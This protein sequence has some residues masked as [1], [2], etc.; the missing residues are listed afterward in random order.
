MRRTY[1]RLTAVQ[2]SVICCMICAVRR[3]LLQTAAGVWLSEEKSVLYTH[4]CTCTLYLSM[5]TADITSVSEKSEYMHLPHRTCMYC[6][7]TC[8]CT[9]TCVY[10][11]MFALHVHFFSCV[12]LLLVCCVHMISRYIYTYM[13]LM[14]RSHCQEHCEVPLLVTSKWANY[15]TVAVD[16]NHRKLQ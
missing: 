13:Y 4:T 9:C 3:N 15:W 11:L 1:T 2:V 16:C 6:A 7:H 12:Y 8:T 5:Y 10:V 14:G